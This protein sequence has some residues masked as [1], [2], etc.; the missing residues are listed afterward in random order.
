MSSTLDKLRTLG[1]AA[2][3]SEAVTDPKRKREAIVVSVMLA[4]AVIGL[5]LLNF[6]EK[7]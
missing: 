2:L 5:I 1:N 7:R 4:P 3:A 6:P